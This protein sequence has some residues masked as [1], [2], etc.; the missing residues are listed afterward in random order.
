MLLNH[1]DLKCSLKELNVVFK[2]ECDK[3]YD[4]ILSNPQNTKSE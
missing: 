3:I 2:L 1:P 4:R